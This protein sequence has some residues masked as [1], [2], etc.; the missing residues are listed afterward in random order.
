MKAQLEHFIR[1]TVK[2]P[3]EA[4]IREILG[5]FSEHS[6]SKGDIFKKSN[7]ISQEL[8]FIV[9]GSARSF[10]VKDNG[11]VI[12]G[13]ITT[14]GNFLAEMMSARTGEPNPI[15]I[16]FL[17]DSLVLVTSIASIRKLLETSLVL[18]ILI[19]EHLTDRIVEIGERFML[20][21]TGTA[22]ER[23]QFFLENNPKLLKKLPLRLIASMI[24]ITPTQLSRIRKEKQ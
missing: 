5:I 14:D 16:E 12:T 6:F 10:I 22:K 24:G 4:E 2:N 21:L 3:D 1:A 18:N 20:F 23:Y 19:R 17:E 11:K 8:G 13:Q 7:T 9:S 15:T